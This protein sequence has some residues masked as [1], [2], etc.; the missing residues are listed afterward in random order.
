MRIQ[1]SLLGE[2]IER[3]GRCELGRSVMGVCR[4]RSRS[5]GSVCR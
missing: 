3:L 5:S 4:A 1:E 2:Q